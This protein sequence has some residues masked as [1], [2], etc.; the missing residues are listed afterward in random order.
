M[1]VKVEVGNLRAPM[2]NILMQAS[3]QIF[4]LTEQLYWGLLIIIQAPFPNTFRQ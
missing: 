2:F 1:D 4:L 3:K